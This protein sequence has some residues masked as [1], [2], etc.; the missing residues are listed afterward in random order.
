MKDFGILVPLAVPCGQDGDIDLDGLQSVCRDML[1]AGCH[2]LF[3]GSSTGRGPWFGRRDGA[4]IC[5]VVA[6]LAGAA[7]PLA[8]GCMASGLADMLDNACAMADAGAQLAVITSPGYYDYND[9][10]VEMILCR[11]ADASPLPVMLYDIPGFARVKLDREVLLRLARHGNIVGLKDSTAD[12]P[13]FR[14]LLPDLEQVPGFYLFQGKERFLASSLGLGASG[15]VVSMIHISPHAFVSLYQ[16][17]RDGDVEE[18]ERIQAAVDRVMDLV[19]SSFKRRPETSTFF[20]FMNQVLR[21]RGI[22]DNILVEH[23]GPCPT[24]LA[25]RAAVAVETLRLIHG[26]SR[27]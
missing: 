15:F 8:A 2:G 21:C 14:E 19:E 12:F 9:A 25:R 23:D 13:R 22:C 17:V 20:H 7:V 4:R 10:E 16:A 11:F 5:R 3:V 26:E 6:D 1:Q 18:A 24:W 27:R